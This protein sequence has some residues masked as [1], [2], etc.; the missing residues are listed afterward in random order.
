MERKLFL[1]LLSKFY[2]SKKFGVS[3]ELLYEILLEESDG[4]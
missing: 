4:P 3:C 2:F 1:A